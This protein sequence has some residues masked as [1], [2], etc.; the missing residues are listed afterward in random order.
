MNKPTLFA[1]VCLLANSSVVTAADWMNEGNRQMASGDV[2]AA[3]VAYASAAQA[4][5]FDA[6]AL[7]NQA[8]A[9][10]A[11]GDYATAT[12]LLVRAVRLAPGRKDIAANLDAVR[13]QA[14]RRD[15]DSYQP[16]AGSADLRLYPERLP[17]EPP[18]L[19]LSSEKTAS[20]AKSPTG[21]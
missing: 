10:S 2:Q 17:P 5:P 19:W 9:L 13:S 8:V 14:A 3:S 7:N 15:G 20:G 21:K 12:Q 1:G 6:V 4:N 18:N 16:Y 11:K